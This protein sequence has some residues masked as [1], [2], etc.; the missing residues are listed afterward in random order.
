[1]R[2]ESGKRGS[3]SGETYYDVIISQ[4]LLPQAFWGEGVSVHKMGKRLEP[5]YTRNNR[6]VNSM[7]SRISE[8]DC[9]PE[10]DPE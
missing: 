9:E 2:T 10:C 7:I 6:I 5:D 1:M 4:I 8:P 3:Y